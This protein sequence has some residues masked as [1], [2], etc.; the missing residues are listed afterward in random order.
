MLSKFVQTLLVFSV[1]DDWSRQAMQDPADF[2]I[3]EDMNFIQS[4]SKE[5]F[6]ILVKKQ[7]KTF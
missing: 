5:C 4:K 3:K 6:K 1:E 2:Q 7:G